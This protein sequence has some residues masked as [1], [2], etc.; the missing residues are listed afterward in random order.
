MLRAV[1]AF[2]VLA[3]VARPVHADAA[4]GG[5]SD[6]ASQAAPSAKADAAAPAAKTSPARP[7]PAPTHAAPPAKTSHGAPA[8]TTHAA[9]AA[10]KTE[11]AAK[12]VEK[13]ATQAE[14]VA[15]TERIHQRISEVAKAQRAANATPHKSSTAK[16]PALSDRAAGVEGPSPAERTARVRLVWRVELVWPEF[17]K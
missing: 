5:A 6:K 4:S 11:A 8:A 9:P 12:P 10:T 7:A 3:A 1:V 14:L 13:P 15:V 2:V 17:E 16:A